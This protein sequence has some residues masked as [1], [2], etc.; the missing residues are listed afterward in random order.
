MNAGYSSGWCEESFGVP[1]VAA[2][3]ECRAKVDEHCRFMMAPPSRI[4]EHIARYEERYDAKSTSFGSVDIP[5]FFQRKRLGDE[6]RKEK[7]FNATLIKTSPALFAAIAA[8][9]RLLLMNE[10]LLKSLGYS[11]QEVVGKDYLSFVHEADWVKLRE[12]FQTIPRGGTTTVG[13]GRM[14]TKDGRERIVEWHGRYILEDIGELDYFFA[15]GI[16]I[17]ERKRA[18]DELRTHRDHLEDLVR[19]RTEI[20]SVTNKRLQRQISERNQ[21]ELALKKSETMLRA[22]FDQT[23]RFVGV[24][25]LD[26]TIV[27]VNKT[28]M[29][30]VH[31]DEPEIRGKA[32]WKTPWW[33]HSTREQER[34]RDAINRAAQGELARFETTHLPGGQ[35][36]NIDFSIFDPQFLVKKASPRNKNVPIDDFQIQHIQPPY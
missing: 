1:L 34:V 2:E 28:A 5:E 20:L 19:K 27:K 31:A 6:F 21:A 36:T 4:K 25:R 24:L 14:V 3:I 26:G 23:F 17:T 10:A 9:G 15:L 35:L 33:V 8:D 22:I 11:H 18:E 29:D 32:F 16:N 30:F 12:F 13:E 7:E